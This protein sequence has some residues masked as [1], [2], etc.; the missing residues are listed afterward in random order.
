[1]YAK[2]KLAFTRT[3]PL[4]CLFNPIEEFFADFDQIL[5]RKIKMYLKQNKEPIDQDTFVQLIHSSLK[6]SINMNIKQIFRRA[7]I[8]E[9]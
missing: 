9:E 5:K 8:L 4:G 1:M 6:D 2:K 7:G 3:P